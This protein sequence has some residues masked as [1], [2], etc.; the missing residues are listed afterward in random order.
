MFHCKVT[1]MMIVDE[2]NVIARDF[3]PW[4]WLWSKDNILA[5]ALCGLTWPVPLPSSEL[6][7]F[8]QI[9]NIKQ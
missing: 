9:P 7:S 4:R 8:Y 6:S 1:K 5:L 2:L 3:G